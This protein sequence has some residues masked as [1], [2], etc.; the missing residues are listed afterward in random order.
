MKTL[1]LALFVSLLAP[2]FAQVTV[3]APSAAV[4]R[5]PAHAVRPFDLVVSSPVS[6]ENFIKAAGVFAPDTQVAAVRLF[7]IDYRQGRYQFA[8]LDS[9]GTP[10]VKGRV[11][12]LASTAPREANALADILT[13]ITSAKPPTTN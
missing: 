7:S 11:F 12:T 5:P 9:K 4:R 8:L 2:A 1:I 6:A 10:L 13:A 3:P